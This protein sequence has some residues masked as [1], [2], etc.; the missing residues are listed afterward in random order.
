MPER[1]PVVGRIGRRASDGPTPGA[2]EERRVYR[3]ASGSRENKRVRFRSVRTE[4]GQR[5]LRHRA[6]RYGAVAL[7]FRAEPGPSS[8]GLVAADVE[9][10]ARRINV[11]SSER[12]QLTVPQA[13]GDGEPGGPAQPRLAALIYVPD[14][15]VELVAGDEHGRTALFRRRL[16]ANHRGGSQEAHQLKKARR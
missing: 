10:A 15:P 9:Q 13:S 14:D 1:V 5:M 4:F 11:S 7:P 6:E 2:G 8:A 3:L 12:A 16:H